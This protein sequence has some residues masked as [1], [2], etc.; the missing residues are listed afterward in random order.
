[1]P[2]VSDSY[3][4]LKKKSTIAAF[5]KVTFFYLVAHTKVNLY[6]RV[7]KTKQK[8]LKDAQLTLKRLLDCGIT[9]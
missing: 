5:F 9:C 3:K 7:L 8:C 2:F 1:M 4:E 6:H